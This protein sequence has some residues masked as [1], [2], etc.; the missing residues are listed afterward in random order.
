MCGVDTAFGAKITKA[1][2][3]KGS[4][5]GSYTNVLQQAFYKEVEDRH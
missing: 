4:V 3:C 5:T 2:S 1:K